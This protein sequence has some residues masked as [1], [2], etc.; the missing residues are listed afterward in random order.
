MKR[1]TTPI[2]PPHFPFPNESFDSITI[3]ENINHVPEVDRITELR[4]AWRCLKPGAGIIVTMGN[5]LAE[6]L[7]HRVV[8][9]YDKY[10]KTSMDMERG[11]CGKMRAIFSRT[12][13]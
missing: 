11:V 7:V 8:Y 1:H 9:F 12:R 2:S 6:I 5:P 10:F 4:E 3:I 13:K